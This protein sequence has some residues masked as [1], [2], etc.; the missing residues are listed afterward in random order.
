LFGLVL[1]PKRKF[2]GVCILSKPILTESVHLVDDKRQK[3]PFIK[4]VNGNIGLNDG[5]IENTLS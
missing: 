2:N 3:Y 5:I 4:V 1:N